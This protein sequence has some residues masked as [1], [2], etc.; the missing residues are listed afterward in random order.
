MTD[1]RYGAWSLIVA[2][3]L[4]AT[5]PS[6]KD[7]VTGP[8]LIDRRPYPKVRFWHIADLLTCLDYVRFQ[9]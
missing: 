3:G 4:R 2:R 5:V 1:E 8:C 7:Q 6:L 9:P